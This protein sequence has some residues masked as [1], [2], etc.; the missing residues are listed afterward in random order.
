[1][2]LVAERSLMAESNMKAL[3]PTGCHVYAEPRQMVVSP[4]LTDMET[5]DAARELLKEEGCDVAI[6]LEA[7]FDRLMMP[8]WLAHTGH[9]TLKLD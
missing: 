5:V 6:L 3:F 9:Q 4:S 7:D 2:R 8:I 1:M